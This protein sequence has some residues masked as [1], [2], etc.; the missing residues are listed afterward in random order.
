MSLQNKE[1]YFTETY[2]K[3]FG[4]DPSSNGKVPILIDGDKTLTE[5]DL[6][7]WYLAENYQTGTN[8]IPND[9]FDKLRLRHFAQ[10][11]GKISGATFGFFGFGKKSQ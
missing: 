3:A 5:S 10:T 9:A 6:I 2:H 8:L 11:H 7:S 4:H 1:P